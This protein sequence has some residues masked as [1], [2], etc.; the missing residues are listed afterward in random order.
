[1]IIDRLSN[2]RLYSKL[3]AGFERAFDYLQQEDL[4]GLP[5]GKYELKGSSLFLMV[6]EYLTKPMGH[7]KW[8]AHRRYIDLQY[9]IQGTEQICYAHLSR[10]QQGSYVEAKD[11]LPLSGEGVYLPMTSGDFM[12]LFPEDGHMPGMAIDEPSPVR[13]AV[14]KIAV[15]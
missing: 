3:G 13:K 5:V 14:F 1:M 7:G 15:E 11:F 9:I 6:Q 8:E 12:I 2:A 10:L 4:P